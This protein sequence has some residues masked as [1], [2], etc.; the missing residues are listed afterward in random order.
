MTSSRRVGTNESISTYYSGGGKDYSLLTTW[1]AATDNNLVTGAVSEVLECYARSHNDRVTLA[2]ATT[3]SSYFRIIRPASSQGHA[4]IP[5]FDG[6][7][8]A[9]ASTVANHGIVAT[10]AYASIQDLVVKL[11]INSTTTYAALGAYNAYAGRSFVG[12]LVVDSVNAGA[13]VVHGIYMAPGSGIDGYIVNCLVHNNDGMGIEGDTGNTY[14]YN[15]TSVGNADYDLVGTAGGNLYAKNVIYGDRSTVNWTETTC[16]NG[17]PAYVDSAN[18][19]FMLAPSDYVAKNQGT[20]LSGDSK[21][22]FDDDILES[23]RGIWDIGFYEDMSVFPPL[24]KPKTNHLL[25]R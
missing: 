6:S 21:F 15:T 14:I 20:N 11:T 7:C 10:E 1:E 19:N 4:G 8:V 2:G 17:S 5:K 22:A 18:D 9:F 13:G 25:R 16:T 23:V 24:F 3:N 12:C